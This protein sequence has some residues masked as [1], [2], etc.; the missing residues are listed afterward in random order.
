M[1]FGCLYTTTMPLALPDPYP[2]LWG[3]TQAAS[4][5]SRNFAKQAQEIGQ[6]ISAFLSDEH[7]NG[8]AVH[9]LQ[10]ETKQHH[11][12][13]QQQLDQVTARQTQTDAQ[14]AAIL[15]QGQWYADRAAQHWNRSRKDGPFWYELRETYRRKWNGKK[16]KV[17]VKITHIDH[18][19]ILWNTYSKY[20]DRLRAQ[21][22]SGI[23]NSNAASLAAERLIPLV[24]QWGD[25]NNA[26]NGAVAP[27][28]V[29][30]NLVEVLAA[31]REQLPSNVE[32]LDLLEGIDLN[33]LPEALRAEIESG[34][35][36]IELID[37]TE[38]EALLPTLQEDLAQ[39]TVETDTYTDK[40]NDGWNEFDTAQDDYTSTIETLLKEKGD[41]QQQAQALQHDLADSEAWVERQNTALATELQQVNALRDELIA[42][43]GNLT[44]STEPDAATK[45]AQLAKTIGAL[46]NKAAILTAE[47]VSLSQKRTLL[48]AQNE[49]VLAEQALIEAY[50]ESP[51]ADF[52]QLQL[53][54]DDARA[55]LAEAQ[56]LA[57]QAEASSNVLTEPLQ[58]LQSKLLE[59]NDEHLAAAKEHKSLLSQLLEV[60]E[61][62]ANYTLKA[63]QKQAE[64]NDLEFQLQTRLQE[65]AEAGLKEAKYL[66]DVATNNDMA[67]AATLYYRDYRDLASDTGG[68]CSGGIAT[69][70]DRIKADRYYREMLK[71]RELQRRARAQAD[72]FGKIKDAADAARK[73]LERR[74]ALLSKELAQLNER[75]AATEAE[76]AEKEQSVAI[77]QARLE[78]ISG[79]RDQTEQ[80]FVQLVTLEQLNLGQAELEREIAEQRQAEIEAAVEARLERERIELERQRLI[81]QSKLE[82]LRQLQTEDDLREALNAARGDLGLEELT[83]GQAPVDVNTQMAALQSEIAALTGAESSLPEEVKALLATV[84][85]DLDSALRGEEAETVQANLL[86]ATE[87]LI[88]QVQHH[89]GQ[90]DLLQQERAR[91]EY[92]L[93]LAE[94]DLQ[95][96]SRLLIKESQEAALLADERKVLDPVQ[97]EVL[98][99]V[100]YAEQAVEIS[101]DLARS[102]FDL[103]EQIIDQRKEERKAREKAFWNEMLSMVSTVLG[104]ISTVLMLIPASAPFAAIAFNIGL[105][106]ALVAGGISATQAAINGDWAGAIF[107]AVMAAASFV[108]GSIGSSL[109]V[110]TAAAK[111]AGQVAL[112]G[113]KQIFAMGIKMTVDTARRIQST[114][115]AMS[116][117]ASGAFNGVRSTLSGDGVLGFLQVLGGV[118]GAITSGFGSTLTQTA[119]GKLGY[120]VLQSLTSAPTAIYGSIRAIESGDLVGG[121]GSIVKTVASLATTWAND[122]NK[123]QSELEKFADIVENVG[124]SAV[125]VSKFVTG[126]FDG[127]LDGLGDILTGLDDN[128]EIW[129]EDLFGCSCQTTK[130][131]IEE[132]ERLLDNSNLTDEEKAKTRKALLLRL[133]A[134]RASGGQPQQESSEK[135]PITYVSADR[136]KHKLFEKIAIWAYQDE[137]WLTNRGSW[138]IENELNQYGYHVVKVIDD[139]NTGMF[140]FVA[141]D[142]NNENPIIS[143]RGTNPDEYQDLIA[144]TDPR[145]I[146][147]NQFE[148]NFSTLKSWSEE[149]KGAVITGHSLGGA[150]S[151][152]Y[153][154]EFA[155]SVD[156]LVTFDSPGTS[157]EAANKFSTKH[158]EVKVSHYV[159]NGDIVSVSG[160]EFLDGKVYV[161]NTK[162]ALGIEKHVE[163]FQKNGL[164]GNPEVTESEISIDEL[165][166]GEF[167]FDS[168]SEFREKARVEIQEFQSSDISLFRDLGEASVEVWEKTEDRETLEKFRQS[169]GEYLRG[170]WKD[171][172]ADEQDKMREWGDIIFK[173]S[174]DASRETIK[175]NIGQ[176]Q[177]WSYTANFLPEETALSQAVYDFPTQTVGI[178][179]GIA[180]QYLKDGSIEWSN[181]GWIDSPKVELHK[182]TISK[183]YESRDLSTGSVNMIVLHH[184]GNRSDLASSVNND[185][186][187]RIAIEQLS[188]DNTHQSAHFLIAKDGSIHQLVST[189]NRAYH[190]VDFNNRSIGIE[191]LGNGSRHPYTDAQYSALQTLL[192][193]LIDHYPDIKFV[194]SHSSV[195]RIN[196][197]HPGSGKN[198]PGEFFDWNRISQTRTRDVKFGDV[199]AGDLYEVRVKESRCSKVET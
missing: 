14:S 87:G 12:R 28:D 20:A 40:V 142:E 174:S 92:L 13:Y 170:A 169:F 16:K 72:R 50:L 41:I 34:E 164:I 52:T 32:Q 144:D 179:S 88:A 113:T 155:S 79:V 143:F 46:D 66:L 120:K 64:T 74:Q 109:K 180:S 181:D 48:A 65:M 117:L 22:V 70:L 148:A 191:I 5:K 185:W 115:A 19:W 9:V 171:L 81:A 57:E 126:G 85:Q 104:L 151:Q 124:Y 90:I 26:A 159:T 136:P 59:Q 147:Y 166:S 128:L 138:F 11:D 39:A 95:Q 33:E 198:D 118:S 80:T 192:P 156:S 107:S 91:D 178:P 132:I 73:D 83:D 163:I 38:L 177:E 150:L 77:A 75:I 189:D 25:A 145:A 84:Q 161:L 187:T 111:Q 158:Q 37:A 96:A 123:E 160:E 89:R 3:T 125:G 93:S 21:G 141:L 165:N 152:L 149:F 139:K 102:S 196:D 54:L 157:H 31:A 56:R 105:G 6:Q 101:E 100:A 2:Y 127:L 121:I 1:R 8:T 194:T 69:D 67:T 154:S 129:I 47:Q 122:F 55:A 188:T 30:R 184:T 42:Q 24:E 195:D 162:T 183:K 71:Y 119:G 167:Q 78:A 86:Q 116:S 182:N 15:A 18:H 27:I 175:S 114:I 137:D 153:T 61:L 133:F 140:A 134:F 4:Q 17:V 146:G 172:S 108:G 29:T 62:K 60:T 97:I 23:V 199:T 51:D 99:K 63:A 186:G 76:K 7:Q 68:R 10:T 130:N 193:E 173:G 98:T 53:Q 58:K 35:A 45:L 190:A 197:A 94:S 36:E 106:L 43:S 168:I 103:L 110:A 135:K 176:P 49:V 82:Q 131:G 44:N 112:E